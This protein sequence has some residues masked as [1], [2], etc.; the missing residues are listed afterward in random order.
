MLF[1]LLLLVLSVAGIPMP[2]P[3]EFKYDEVNPGKFEYNYKLSD[4]DMRDFLGGDAI[5]K[6]S[7]KTGTTFWQM[8][9]GVPKEEF[10]RKVMQ[11]LWLKEQIEDPSIPLQNKLSAAGA[12]RRLIYDGSGDRMQALA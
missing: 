1:P 9:P 2:S 10:D 7:K 5:F 8:K 3:F 4:A 11:L 12:M 6:H